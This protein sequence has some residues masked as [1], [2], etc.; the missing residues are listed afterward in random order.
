MMTTNTESYTA[1]KKTLIE[2]GQLFEG[3]V[4]DIDI[5][6]VSDAVAMQGIPVGYAMV[7]MAVPVKLDT[8]VPALEMVTRAVARG[9]LLPNDIAGLDDNLMPTVGAVYVR[10]DDFAHQNRPRVFSVKLVLTAQERRT[11]TQVRDV[12]YEVTAAVVATSQEEADAL[13]AS[14][15]DQIGEDAGLPAG[16]WTRREREC[17]RWETDDTHDDDENEFMHRECE[18]ENACVEV[19]GDAPYPARFVCDVFEDVDADAVIISEVFKKR[20]QTSDTETLIDKL[21]PA[22][23]DIA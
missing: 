19:T 14:D 4:R 16:G 20:F 3:H 1:L 11:V 2:S 8:T 7:M 10:A 9:L 6:T 18:P 22:G 13:A 21:F 15:A 23:D 12:V 5:A 17:G